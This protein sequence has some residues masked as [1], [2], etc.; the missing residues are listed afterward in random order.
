MGRAYLPLP[1]DALV[2]GVEI[3][4]KVF[5]LRVKEP[6]LLFSQDWIALADQQEL[7]I[8]VHASEFIGKG[9]FPLRCRCC[10]RISRA[11]GF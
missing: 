5:Q 8:V 10:V 9:K 1:Y 3:N 6:I 11:I 7:L 2:F 4:A